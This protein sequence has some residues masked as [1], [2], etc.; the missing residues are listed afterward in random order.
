MMHTPTF[1]CPWCGAP[2]TG[3][4]PGATFACPYCQAKVTAPY[5]GAHAQGPT[6]LRPSV[7]P[8][9]QSPTSGGSAAAG[10]FT[11]G[12]DDLCLA[13]DARSGFT[14]VGAYAPDGQPP[15]LRAWSLQQKRQQWESQQGLAW[16][17]N[18]GGAA[19]NAAGPNVYVANARSLLALSLATGD[20]RWAA[21]LPDKVARGGDGR[22]CVVDAFAPE[23]RGAVVVRTVDNVLAAFDR[24][25]GQPLWSRPYKGDFSLAPVEGLGVVTARHN[26]PYV[27]F[28][29]FN[30]GYPNLIASLGADQHWSCD[31][32]R[33]DVVGRTLL[34]HV[35]DFGPDDDQD[36]V[37]L[38]D[39]PTGRVHFFMQVEDLAGDVRGAVMGNIVFCAVN[40]GEGM[41]VGPQGRVVGSP[42]PSHA[43]A[44]LCAGG[45]SLFVLLKKAQGTPVR[46]LV[47]LDP[48]SLAFRFD[49]GEQGAEPSD[50]WEEQIATNGF[51]VVVVATP[52]DDLDGAELRAYD[53]TTG[54]LAWRRPARGWRRHHFQG[55]WLVSVTRAGLEILDPR[56]GQPTAA[57]PA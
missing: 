35:E 23:G 25:T 43:I 38:V 31:F 33:S 44:S 6:S 34:C 30:P 47:G 41:W 52:E 12:V 15:R 7:P 9:Q 16:V 55:G 5:P 18:V 37:M 14:L 51:V 42:V 4:A 3:S 57:Y 11:A 24:D 29:I 50:D 10:P 46:R 20:K 49:C 48:I 26:F 32:D 2:V 36:G 1:P 54:R 8:A 19:M 17:A 45:P 27:R 22:A 56:S 53:T 21:Q 39:A 13:H 28:D 40:D